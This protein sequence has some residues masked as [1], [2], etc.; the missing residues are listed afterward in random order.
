[1]LL[2]NISILDCTLRDGGY[3]NNWAFE[4]KISIKIVDSL[5]ESKIE[6]IEIGYLNSK[7][8]GCK[9]TTK[10]KDLLYTNNII[11][12]INCQY[13]LMLNL[14]D[15]NVNNIEYNPNIFGIRLAFHKKDW[16]E[17]L[18]EASKLIE[19][20]YNVFIQPMVTLSYS[21]SELLELIDAFN[22][23]SIYAFYIVDSFG[24][25]QRADVLRLSLLVDNNLKKDVK[26]GFHAHNNLQLAYSNAITLLET[27]KNRKLI[28]D[29][30]VFGMGR[31]AGNLNTELFADNLIRNYNKKYKIEPLLDIIDDFLSLIYRENYWGY[32]VAHY[33]SA[34]YNCHPNYSTYLVEKKKL[35]VKSIKSIIKK[36]KES[37]KY[38]F[39]KNYIEKLYLEFNSNKTFLYNYELLKDIFKGRDI[40]L[41]APGQSIKNNTS[42]IQ[43]IMNNKILSVSINHISD[44][45]KTDYIFFNNEKRYIEYKNKIEYFRLQDRLILA[46]NLN[47]DK[48]FN[49]KYESFLG[50]SDEAQDNATIMFLKLLISFGI[51]NAYIAGLDGYEFDKDSYLSN[52]MQLDY[53][54][55]KINSINTS[56]LA[57]LKNI[58]NDIN[59]KFVTPSRFSALEI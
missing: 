1:M 39:D 9:D 58:R 2:G 34:I 41:I 48:R 23:L 55:G 46:S 31:G 28:I 47:I 30:S 42:E 25:M 19:I 57:E 32:S 21:D 16:R 5:I 17:A 43:K 6:Y 3:I 27:L 20:G 54:K 40:L 51:K 11:K 37:K 49:I 15:F 8:G 14:G 50:I 10:F 24:A 35:T 36:I 18:G 38:D 44:L 7:N 52:E 12:S 26:L 22:Q 29:T 13:L 56:I 45:Y 33:I 4:D 59:I 53:T